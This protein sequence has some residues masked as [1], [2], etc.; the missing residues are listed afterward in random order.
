VF[1]VENSWFNL[2]PG[3]GTVSYWREQTV[4]DVTSGEVQYCGPGDV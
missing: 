1:P 4:T 2:R 3:R